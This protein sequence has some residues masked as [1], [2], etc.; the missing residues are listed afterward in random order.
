[1]ANIRK[2][3]VYYIDTA[4]SQVNFEQQG[5]KLIGVVL[6]RGTAASNP[7]LIIADY[8]ASSPPTV[9]KLQ[10]ATGVDTQHFD[11]STSPI[12]LPNGISVPASGLTT[13]A[14]ATLIL[15]SNESSRK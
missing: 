3:N 15:S 14:N 10:L 2:G 4:A 13:N 12:S 7:T 6:N 9:L 1:M 11:F 8:H 5:V